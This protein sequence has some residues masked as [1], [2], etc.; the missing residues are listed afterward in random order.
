MTDTCKSVYDKLG[1][2]VMCN[3]DLNG[4]NNDDDDDNDGDDNR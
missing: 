4:N 2:T 3:C 1:L